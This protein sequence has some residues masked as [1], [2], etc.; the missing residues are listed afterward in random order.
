MSLLGWLYRKETC[1]S[2]CVSCCVLLGERA[3]AGI[4]IPFLSVVPLQVL[5]MAWNSSCMEVLHSAA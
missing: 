5:E 1:T 2:L 4:F 3:R